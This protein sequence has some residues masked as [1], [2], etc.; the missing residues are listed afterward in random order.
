[1]DKIPG[2]FLI[3]LYILHCPHSTACY[4]SFVPFMDLVWTVLTLVISHFPFHTM[5]LQA[6]HVCNSTTEVER[7]HTNFITHPVSRR[8]WHS[9]TCVCWGGRR[10]GFVGMFFSNLTF[11]LSF[12]FS[13][14][15]CVCESK[16]PV[17]PQPI[18]SC[19]I[20]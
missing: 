7:L 13:Y 16:K 3:I 9:G 14:L 18:L 8:V 6:W 20:L 10:G 19:Q 15:I 17:H 4:H 1:M 5:S 12:N 2:C 11:T